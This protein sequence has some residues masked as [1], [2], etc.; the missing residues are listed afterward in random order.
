MDFDASSVAIEDKFLKLNP[1]VKREKLTWR[2]DGRLEWRC[3]DGV[4]HT[5]FSPKEN[6]YTHGCDGCCRLIKIPKWTK[7]ERSLER[8]LT[9][10]E[11]RAIL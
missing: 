7:K 11:Q 6:D 8:K 2:L 4:G 10:W 3:K 5:I 9:M 1:D